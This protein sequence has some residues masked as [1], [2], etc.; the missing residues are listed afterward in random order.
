MSTL[1]QEESGKAVLGNRAGDDLER[2][3]PKPKLIGFCPGWVDR[4]GK[5][6]VRR[7]CGIYSRALQDAHQIA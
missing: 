2:R 7:P 4:G 5:R 1:H 6:D 3:L